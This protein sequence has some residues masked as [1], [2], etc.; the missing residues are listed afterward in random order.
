MW[1]S[2]GVSNFFLRVGTMPSRRGDE[3]RIASAAGACC[4]SQSTRLL[5]SF[6]VLF[7]N[8]IT[9][10]KNKFLRIGLNMLV[11][12]I[13]GVLFVFLVPSLAILGVISALIMACGACLVEIG[14]IMSIV[15]YI[16]SKKSKKNICRGKNNYYCNSSSF[17][18]I[19]FS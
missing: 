9:K 18:N 11:Y 12:G 15:N 1:Q 5:I 4:L 10:I 8:Y 19:F 16:S 14:L 7:I 13:A 3:I 2:T 17:N 6:F